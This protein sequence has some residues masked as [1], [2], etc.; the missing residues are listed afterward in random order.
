M[1][2]G[3]F[4]SRHE[5]LTSSQAPDD[6]QLIPI[7][8]QMIACCRLQPS[9]LKSVQRLHLMD[10]LFLLAR[11]ATVSSASAAAV[12]SSG[13]DVD[14]CMRT[15]DEDRGDPPST[16]LKPD[17]DC[18]SSKSSATDSATLSVAM[19]ASKEA[20]E[21]ACRNPDACGLAGEIILRLANYAS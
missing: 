8:V 14:A 20:A 4:S 2:K 18:A 5:L 12:S 17:R 11:S 7:L 13:S 16:M 9:N 6:K 10:N 1:C 21:R 3:C 19:A 15:G